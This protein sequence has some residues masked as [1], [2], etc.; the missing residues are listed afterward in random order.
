MQTISVT[1]VQLPENRFRREFD[2]GKIKELAESIDSK[3]LLHPIVLRNDRKTLV[4]GE[5]RLKA[6]VLLTLAKRTIV[7]NGDLVPF[8]TIPFTTLSDLNPLALREA[9]FEE[10]VVRSDFTWFERSQALASLHRFRTEQAAAEGR[11]QTLASTAE[12]A[13]GTPFQQTKVRNALLLSDYAADPEVRAAKSEKEAFNIVKRK[14]T[15]KFT[16]AL[17]KNIKAET[18][19]TPHVALEGDSM[20]LLASLDDRVF[21]V[22]ITDPPF[23]IDAHLFNATDGNESA[24]RHA[25]DDSREYAQSLMRMIVDESVRVCKNDAALYMFC[26]YEGYDWLVG[27]VAKAGWVPWSRPII[28][29]KPGGG[30]MGDTLHGPR[31][32]YETILFAYR[33][34]KRTTGTFLDVIV[35]QPKDEPRHAAAKPWEVYANL[36]KRS[37]VPGMTVLDPC[38]GIG[39]IFPAANALQLRATGIEI[40]NAHYN[41]ALTRINSKE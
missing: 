12:E 34:N 29:H 1:D 23:G 6:I 33:G 28:W 19:E 16:A 4:S 38:M 30:M 22:L 27:L 21:D 25:Y 13:T 31:R 15:D 9:E 18:K 17:A 32:S 35:H 40:V 5:R 8:G 24:T 37:T 10:N 7:H 2:E 14:L 3:G 20:K 11:T 39:P 36:L 26:D 41:T